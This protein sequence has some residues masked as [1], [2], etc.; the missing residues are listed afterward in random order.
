[1]ILVHR[2]AVL[3]QNHRNYCKCSMACYQAHPDSGMT[4]S[5]QYIRL[6]ME[7]E[8]ETFGCLCAEDWVTQQREQLGG[9]EGRGGEGGRCVSVV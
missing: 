6:I 4:L 1:M 9:G 8:L 2:D 5:V 7:D 3:L